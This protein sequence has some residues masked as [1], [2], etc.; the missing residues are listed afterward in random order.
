M[1]EVLLK[2]DKKEMQEKGKKINL[3]KRN[4]ADQQHNQRKYGDQNP[5]KRFGGLKSYSK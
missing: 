3:K 2:N 1:S 4:M 5:P